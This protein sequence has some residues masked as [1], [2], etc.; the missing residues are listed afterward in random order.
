MGTQDSD[1]VEHHEESLT[2]QKRFGKDVKAV[3][4]LLKKK[5][6]PFLPESGPRLKSYG[7][8]GDVIDDDTLV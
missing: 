5:G 3:Y 8:H 6:N 7:R 2:F 4:N 1:A